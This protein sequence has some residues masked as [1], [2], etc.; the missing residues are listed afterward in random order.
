M[1]KTMKP[2]HLVIGIIL[3][4]IF[5]TAGWLTVQDYR[6][7]WS[8]HGAEVGE[9]LFP[10]LVAND[11]TQISAVGS[12]GTVALKKQGKTWVVA[13]RNGYPA[14][15]QM[16]AEL[17]LK[18]PELKVVQSFVVGPDDLGRLD[19]N[20]PGPEV[21]DSGTLLR[22]A[23]ADGKVLAEL[24]LGKEHRD[25]NP[26]PY[27]G[28]YANGRYILLPRDGDVVLVTETFDSVTCRNEDWV[29][30]TFPRVQA[31]T[32][33]G[34]FRGDEELWAIELAEAGEDLV[35]K[36]DI[37]PGKE[38]DPE[39]LNKVKEVL[40]WLSFTSVGDPAKTDWGFGDD[41]FVVQ[42]ANGLKYTFTVGKR[43][44][45]YDLPV[46]VDVD[47]DEPP[48]APGPAGE[49]PDERANRETA[50][51]REV[52]E[53]RGKFEYERALY[54]GWVYLLPRASHEPML[55]TVDDLV[56]V[57]LA[58]PAQDADDQNNENRDDGA[59]AADDIE[60]PPEDGPEE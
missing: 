39:R 38:A 51:N 56:R 25:E 50:H 41:R 26:D 32:Y 30:K 43:T 48:L 10:G 21:A 27:F 46:R 3:L 45:R 35:L 36:G 57:A 15:F 42:S 13:S 17:V 9:L 24:V 20:L 37:P 29:D 34:R 49:T 1:R 4:I 8:R 11:V 59:G 23:D 47:Y 40:S 44:E 14:N 33:A 28:R 12:D 5:G 31:L 52:E 55:Y 19:L 54:N 7:N 60:L 22:F 53:T 16:L 58:P 18:L 2:K 6:K